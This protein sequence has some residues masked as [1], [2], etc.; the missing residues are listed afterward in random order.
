MTTFKP[1]L[2]TDVRVPRPIKTY[3]T[4]DFGNYVLATDIPSWDPLAGGTII[5]LTNYFSGTIS[6][7]TRTIFQLHNNTANEA[8][9]VR[10]VTG[11]VNTAVNIRRNNVATWTSTLD[12]F[13]VTDTWVVGEPHAVALSWDA[14]KALVFGRGQYEENLNLTGLMPQALTH[15]GIGM[16][17]GGADSLNTTARIQKLYVF[18]ETLTKEQIAAFI[19]REWNP[20]KVITAGQSNAAYRIKNIADAN[21]ELGWRALKENLAVNCLRD[22]FYINGATG[23]SAAFKISDPSN[24]WLDDVTG[25]YGTAFQTWFNAYNRFGGTV[26]FIIWDQ[27]EADASTVGRGIRGKNEYKAQLLRI[28]N[29]FWSRSPDAIIILS[30][31]GRRQTTD[32]NNLGYQF[33]REGQA[34][35][36][37]E[38]EGRIVLGPPRMDLAL[39]DSVHL[40]NAGYQALSL[41]DARLVRALLGHNT[42]LYPRITNATRVGPAVTVTLLHNAGTDFTPLT[43]IEGFFYLANGV[44][45]S[46]NNAIRTTSGSSTVTIAHTAHGL[47]VGARVTFNTPVTYNGVTLDRTYEVLSV[48]DANRYTLGV[49]QQA[50]ATDGVG[51]GGSIAPVYHNVVAITAAVRAS[52]TTITL[53]LASG[54]AGTL[55]HHYGTMFTVNPANLVRDNS[56]DTLPLRVSVRTVT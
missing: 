51:G 8:L 22:V 26:D 19:D 35:L 10:I 39:I 9:G 15:L 24:F 17:N 6:S 31:I 52:A 11:T 20:I 12:Q 46:L 45:Q 41:R 30:P 1:F 43:G 23:G 16:R 33:I 4:P 50:T 7:F 2:P 37:A 40:T 54:V 3:V 49:A 14:T 32:S 55:Y 36:A 21:G 44:T 53:T 38:F 5:A 34:E 18:R 47:A 29:V 13:D 25:E 28:F 42:A 27:G 56:T 48:P